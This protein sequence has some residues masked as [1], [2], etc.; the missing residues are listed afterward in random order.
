[1]LGSGSDGG[2]IYRITTDGSSFTMLQSFPI[3]GPTQFPWGGLVL[4]SD[5]N[6]YGTTE[7]G[8]GGGTIFSLSP[9]NVFQSLYTFTGGADGA[10]PRHDGLIQ[11]SNDAYYGTTQSGGLVSPGECRFGCGTIFKFV[12]GAGVTTVHQ[13]DGSSGDGP[14]AGVIEGRDHRLYGT[15]NV[16]GSHG[17]GIVFRVGLNGGGYVVLHH[18][19]GPEGAFP[20]GSLVQ[21]SDGNFYGTTGTGGDNDTGVVYRITPAGAVATL[22]SFGVL[23]GKNPRAAV[24][25]AS[26]GALYGTTEGGGAYNW[27]TIYRITLDGVFN[28]YHDFKGSDGSSPE[29]A[30]YQASDGNLYGTTRQG[31]GFDCIPGYIECG[32]VFRLTLPH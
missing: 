20:V 14:L 7:Y 9:A 4:G 2:G 18:F 30:L 16:G 25:Q 31:G 26:D 3:F 15:T 21:A 12:P 24:M 27:G 23:D 19:A 32:T 10:T 6:F 28:V 13:F 5:G 11:A 29:A 22:H 17:K 1:V 8:G